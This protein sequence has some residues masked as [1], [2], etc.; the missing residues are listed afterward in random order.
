MKQNWIVCFLFIF[1]PRLQLDLFLLY[2][3]IF[4]YMWLYSDT[5]V[6]IVFSLIYKPHSIIFLYAVQ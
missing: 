2:G 1:G 4:L 5:I 6:K 3:K